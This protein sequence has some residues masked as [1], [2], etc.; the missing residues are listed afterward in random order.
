MA[1]A[2]DAT[3]W[4]GVFA[5]PPPVWMHGNCEETAYPGCPDY[6]RRPLSDSATTRRTILPHPLWL[7][8]LAAATGIHTHLGHARPDACLRR[9]SLREHHAR[10][11]RP[12]P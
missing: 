12:G 4:L 8:R 2:I 11:H 3:E 7:A 1:H 9:G 6:Q 10:L 5:C